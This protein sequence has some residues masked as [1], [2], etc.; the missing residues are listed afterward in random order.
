M[1]K[2]NLVDRNYKGLVQNNSLN[3]FKVASYD[4]FNIESRSL[5]IGVGIAAS[6]ASIMLIQ[7]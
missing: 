4:Y 3:E 1:T 2:F 7:I 6:T 5:R